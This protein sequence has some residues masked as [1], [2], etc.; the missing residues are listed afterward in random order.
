MA[1]GIVL[2]PMDQVVVDRINSAIDELIEEFNGYADMCGYQ[3]SYKLP[4]TTDIR[5]CVS[6]NKEKRTY[7]AWRNFPGLI[8]NRDTLKDVFDKVVCPNPFLTMEYNKHDYN[9][10]TV[11]F[12]DLNLDLVIAIVSQ[13]LYAVYDVFWVECD[14]VKRR[15]TQTYFSKAAE[16]CY[17]NSIYGRRN[18][19]IADACCFKKESKPMDF[20]KII[21]NGPAT[22]GWINGKKY[23]VKCAE[24]DEYD[25]EKAILALYVK[26][27]FSSDERFHGWMRKTLKQARKTATTEYKETVAVEKAIDEMKTSIRRRHDRWTQSE[28]DFLYVHH[29]DMSNAEIATALGRSVASV[30]SQKSV[31]KLTKRAPKKPD[32]SEDANNG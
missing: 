1:T 30:A 28:V 3:Y 13:M 19:K 17:L 15:I 10:L 18:C 27:I 5:Y 20:E 11:Y 6:T 14:D 31:C 29:N 9:T 7:L 23:V 32:I 21:V 2:D 22:I 4:N 24:E 16:K 25:L 8:K 12:N 26:S